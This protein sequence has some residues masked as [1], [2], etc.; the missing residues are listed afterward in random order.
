MLAAT[1]MILYIIESQ[2]C[3]T[4]KIPVTGKEVTPILPIREGLLFLPIALGCK[5]IPPFIMGSSCLEIPNR[6][7]LLCLIFTPKNPY[8][9]KLP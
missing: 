8:I 3:T 6:A 1:I 4:W 5:D 2:N 7:S 9:Y